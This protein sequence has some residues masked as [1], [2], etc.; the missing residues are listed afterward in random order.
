MIFR[1]ILYNGKYCSLKK[2]KFFYD[3]I[4]SIQFIKKKRLE[5]LLKMIIKQKYV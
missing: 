3:N 1:R 5:F 4:F 2:S